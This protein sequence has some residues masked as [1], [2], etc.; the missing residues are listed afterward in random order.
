[1]QSFNIKNLIEFDF[2]IE[3]LTLNIT[4]YLQKFQSRIY[5]KIFNNLNIFLRDLL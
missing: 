3:S 1:M 5:L 4:K 2:E